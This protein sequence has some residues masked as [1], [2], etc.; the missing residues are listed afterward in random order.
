MPRS[1]AGKAAPPSAEPVDVP[2]EHG[3]PGHTPEQEQSQ[4]GPEPDPR[5]AEELP[6]DPEADDAP[7]PADDEAPD[8]QDREGDQD[9]GGDEESSAASLLHVPIKRKGS[10]KR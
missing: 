9:P 8:D 2:V 5:A 3:V 1:G 6:S 10:R 4:A 7:W